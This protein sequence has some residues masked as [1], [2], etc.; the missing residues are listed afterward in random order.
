MST[1][2]LVGDGAGHVRALR[3]DQVRAGPPAAGCSMLEPVVGSTFELRCDLVL[4]ALGFA[5]AERQGLV[6]GLGLALTDRGTA[7]AGAG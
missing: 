7:A 2:E 5:G 4:L 1:A 3:A 6:A